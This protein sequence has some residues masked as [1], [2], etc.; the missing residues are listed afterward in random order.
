MN[1]KVFIPPHIA[2]LMSA[3]DRKAYGY[4]TPEEQATKINLVLE[5]E[6]HSQLSGWL[7]RNGFAYPYHSDPTRRPT[8]LAGMPDY[9]IHRG[10]RILFVEIKLPS[11]TYEESQ[12][13]AFAAIK[14]QGDTIV[15]AY[16]YEEAVAAIT[17]FFDL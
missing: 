7:S 13:I 14:A 6:I 3:S 16:S 4:L 11:G 8:I 17:E 2:K 5:R 9:G 15:T 12:R 10:G 1:R